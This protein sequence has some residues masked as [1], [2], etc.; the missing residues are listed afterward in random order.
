M[1][2]LGSVNSP[3]KATDGTITTD[4]MSSLDTTCNDVTS[5]CG[6]VLY[7]SPYTHLISVYHVW[8]V[9]ISG[10]G[11]QCHRHELTSGTTGHPHPR[12]SISWGW[13]ANSTGTLTASVLTISG[14]K[15]NYIAFIAFTRIWRQ[16]RMMT[17]RRRKR[18]KLNFEVHLLIRKYWIDWMVFFC[19]QLQSVASSRAMRRSCCF[20]SR[21]NRKLLP[22]GRP[23][24]W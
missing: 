24:L 23:S 2:C 11:L 17:M 4:S 3:C 8:L 19:L 15:L 5:P 22:S 18:V 14:V 20:L 16:T 1:Q 7:G 13:G 9:M 12:P 10:W 21:W 6:R